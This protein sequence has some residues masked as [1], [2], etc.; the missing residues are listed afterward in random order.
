MLMT[1]CSGLS[2]EIM[3]ATPAGPAIAVCASRR[4]QPSAARMSATQSAG[5]DGARQHSLDQARRCP[6]TGSAS[7]ETR[8]RRL[9]SRR[10]STAG[11]VPPASA[12]LRGP[13]PGRESARGRALRKSSR[14]ARRMSSDST[15]EVS[16][17]GQPSACAIGVRM[18][19]LPSC[20]SIR[21]VDVFRPANARCSADERPPSTCRAGKPNN[22]HASISSSPLFMSVAESTEILRPMTQRGC[23]QA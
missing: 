3:H 22:R 23:A 2:V 18:S 16:R 15:P 20:A 21:A 17:S 5:I 12:A 6:E 14:A 8:Q 9:R 19:G 13:G 11:A 4:A 7:R 1:D 10:S